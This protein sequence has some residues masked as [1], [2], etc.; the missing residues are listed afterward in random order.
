MRHAGLLALLVAISAWAAGPDWLLDRGPYRTAV[1]ASA[2]G[3]E[4][5]ISNGLLRRVWRVTP[6]GA[7]VALDNL[8]TGASLLRGVKPE[9]RLTIDGTAVP[10][11]GLKGQ[12]DYAYLMPRW[13]ESM[14]ADPAAL[15]LIRWREVPVEPRMEWKRV[16]YSSSQVWPPKGVGLVLEFAADS[17]ALAGLRADV[18][19]EMYDGLPL[20][21]KWV[22]V[23][24]GTAKK[25]R[26]NSFASEILA[27][28]EDSSAVESAPVPPASIHVESD[29]SFGGMDA[30]TANHTTHWESDPEYLTQVSYE[31]RSPVLMESR[32]PLGPEVDLAQG[33]TLESF[34]TFELVFDST[35]RERRGL[36][37]RRMYRT[38]APWAAENPILMHVRQ[39]DD[40]TV[41]RAIDQCAE[42]GFEMVILSF[43]SGFRA[44]DESDANL[45]RLKAL[46]DYARSKGIE[47]GGYSLLASRK[48]SPEDDVI[49]PKTGKTGGAIFGESPC[50]GSRWAAEYFRK[51][52]QL[53]ERTG[54]S[55][56]EHDGSYPG[57]VC[58]SRSHPGHRDLED[59]QW[60]QFA[61]IREFYRWARGRGIYLNVPDWYYLNG[62]SKS[63]M[64]YRE[65]NWS[66]PRE[67]Q[68][69]LG[70][71]NIYDGTWEKTPSMGWMFVP[72]TEYQGGRAAATLEPLKDHLDAY[73]QHL[74]QNFG[75]GVQACYRGPRLYDS[76]ETKAV[77]KRWVDFYKTHR[78]IL[79]S[80]VIHL[81]RADGRD[82]DG[83]LHV[84]PATPERGLAMLFNPTGEAL[85][86]R[87]RLPL[88]YAGLREAATVRVEGGPARK[89]RL[90]RD[91]STEIDVTIPAGRWTNVLVT[92]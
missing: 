83:M 21:A 44:E 43:G 79:D 39:S 46:A 81:R 22:T 60:R 77:V 50:L 9:A 37:Q 80:D 67:R 36:A 16:R 75:F 27:V 66:L 29:Y 48:V 92:P 64:G 40:E 35:D 65:T 49:N 8:M 90:A 11:G 47:L 5:T 58:A 78:A 55:L 56:L 88:Y 30:R 28:V 34:R 57:D 24:N 68:F 51:L 76:E 23:S 1:K 18:H 3:K 69:V 87:V 85:K 19:Y 42:A 91:F 70:R 12:P 17:G 74:A 32:P 4:V 53:F 86:R 63:G 25:I 6:D 82:W 20:I 84:N 26:L 2:D 45:A 52:R 41:R 72:L 14:T 7:T 61:V 54:L 10:V 31:R 15:H 62:S 59:S 89:V 38:V 73:E 33:E 71:Q 13:L